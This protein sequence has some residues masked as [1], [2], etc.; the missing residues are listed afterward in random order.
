MKPV[1]GSAT[2]WTPYEE[3]LLR[4]GLA[5]RKHRVDRIR[6]NTGWSFDEFLAEARLLV[7]KGLCRWDPAKGATKE[8]WLAWQTDFAL[9]EIERVVRRVRK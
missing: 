3:Q 8:K 7:W 5:K 4:A 1:E 9:R 2:D 6:H